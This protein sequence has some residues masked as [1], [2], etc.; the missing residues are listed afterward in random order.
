MNET[1]PERKD[2]KTRWLQFWHSTQ[3]GLIFAIGLI[4][5]IVILAVPVYTRQTDVLLELNDVSNQAHV[6]V[7]RHPSHADRGLTVRKSPLDHPLIL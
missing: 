5:V 4:G 3:L 6:V 2:F 7:E 1:Q